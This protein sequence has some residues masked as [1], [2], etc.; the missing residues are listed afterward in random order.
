[1]SSDVPLPLTSADLERVA[2]E[3]IV[4]HGEAAL[5]KAEERVRALRSEGFESMARTWEL[6]RDA[7]LRKQEKSVLRMDSY[8]T[9][10]NPT[11]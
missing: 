3:L 10:L 11:A 7:V 6:I 9:A 2:E 8:R 1:M 4:E 5:E